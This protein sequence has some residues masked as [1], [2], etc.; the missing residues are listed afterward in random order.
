MFL[1]GESY[2]EKNTGF[3]VVDP[4]E[5]VHVDGI[6]RIDNGRLD[7]GEFATNS[8]A[9]QIFRDNSRGNASSTLVL[10][11][12]EDNENNDRVEIRRG[13]QTVFEFHNSGSAYKPGGGSWSVLSDRRA[14]HDINDLDGS[15]E[16]LMGLRGVTYYYNDPNAVGAAEGLQTGFIAQ[17]I[18]EVFPEW[19]GEL[20]DGTKTVS[21]KGFEALTVESIRELRDE[22][23]AQIAELRAENSDLADRLAAL[24]ALVA[25]MNSGN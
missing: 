17:E 12:G 18:E 10:R 13:S 14:K 4:V 19:V 5:R 1:G 15:L 6:A 8:D 16:K 24:E 21:I 9:I 2:F 25:E 23:D 7:F 20:E 3:G 22:K 11:V